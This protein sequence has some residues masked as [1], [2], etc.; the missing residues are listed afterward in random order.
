MNAK[1]LRQQYNDISWQLRQK[2]YYSED[3]K[4]ELEQKLKDIEKQLE[5]LEQ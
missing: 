4:R 2:N 3:V 1:I 5:K